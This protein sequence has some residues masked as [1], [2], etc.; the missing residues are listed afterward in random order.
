MENNCEY[1][2]LLKESGLKKTKHRTTILEFL[3]EAKQPVTAEQLYDAL[4]EKNVSINLSTV[5]RTLET[6]QDKQLILKH[7]VTNENKAVFEY[8][9]REHKH[10][11]VCIGCKK[12][13]SV[14]NCPLGDYEKYLEEKTDFIITG[15]KL[16]MYGY[17]SECQ[18]KGLI[19]NRGS[20]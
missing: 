5:Y 10:Y 3:R 16:D 19:L 12:I 14:E 20:K 8:N 13:L 17:C 4:K 1:E 9:N 18:R 2:N 7:T 11:L 15:H 6:L